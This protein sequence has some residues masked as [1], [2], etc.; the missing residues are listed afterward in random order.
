M[1]RQKYCYLFLLASIPVFTKAQD[2][3]KT[4]SAYFSEVRSG[5][6][7]SI[8]KNLFQPEN[9]AK[10]LSLITPYL[11]DTSGAVRSKA[12]ALIQ[13]TGNT[14]REAH[15][16][17]NSVAKLIEAVKD[18]DSGNAGQALN[19]LTGFR[20]E[21]FTPAAR[22]TIRAL[23]TRKTPHYDVL[24]RLTG[25]LELK[26]LQSALRALSQQSSASKK[27]RW[28]ALLALSRMGDP[29]AI[30]SVLS[31]VKRL[32]VTDEV[33]YEIFPDLVYTRQRAVFDLLIDALNSDAKNC[34]SANAASESKIPCAYRVMEMLA[35]AVVNY[36][37]PLD[38]SGDIDTKDYKT[39]L[40]TVREWFKANK[41]YTI[42][43]TNY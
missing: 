28:S 1:I 17:E 18:R 24:I 6:Y 42:S 29:Y 3:K 34:E 4:L 12:Y 38:A 43:K 9:V 5:K 31:R 37:L 19:Y 40:E 11:T 2:I 13:L 8:P 27:D 36:P 25:F 16:R 23:F 41:D 10:T 15:L 21:D 32:P 14:T 22:D 7:Q 35:M 39:A 33:V 30:E 20:Q 26:P